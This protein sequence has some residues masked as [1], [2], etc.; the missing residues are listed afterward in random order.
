MMTKGIK[1]SLILSIMILLIPHFSQAQEG[2]L[3][4]DKQV[5][6]DRITSFY[7]ERFFS[8]PAISNPEAGGL[9]ATEIEETTPNGERGFQEIEADEEGGTETI[10]A[11]PAEGNGIA[12]GAV[13][14]AAVPVQTQN[15]QPVAPED[16]PVVDGNYSFSPEQE[17]IIDDI[18]DI[19]PSGI[20]EE[21][22]A[23]FAVTG[24]YLGLTRVLPGEGEIRISD[25]ASPDMFKYTLL[26]EIGHIIDL[27]VLPDSIREKFYN[28]FDGNP[29]NHVTNYSMSMP[30]EDFAET[31][32]NY[33]TNHDAVLAKAAFSPLL[34]EK[35]EIIEEI[36][37]A[38]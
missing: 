4:I 5:H 23:I 1:I 24:D 19:L 22:E 13:N 7:S 37:D 32:A 20:L 9:S 36:I 38:F 27:Y 10:D 25:I 17:A 28:L 35:V 33:L 18:L 16:V 2:G 11:L 6:F 34:E 29:N 30:E 12:Q 14:A 26:H 8:W 31:W 3:P 21:I 15:I